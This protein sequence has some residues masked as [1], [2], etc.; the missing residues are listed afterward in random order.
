MARGL[1][2]VSNCFRK[3]RRNVQAMWLWRSVVAENALS[4]RVARNLLG[5][6]TFFKMPRSLISSAVQFPARTAASQKGKRELNLGLS[7]GTTAKATNFPRCSRTARVAKRRTSVPPGMVCRSTGKNKWTL[8]A[9]FLRRSFGKC[10]KRPKSAVRTTRSATLPC[11]KW[12]WPHRA[13]K[14]K[15]RLCCALTTPLLPHKAAADGMMLGQHC[16]T[17]TTTLRKIC[18]ALKRP[19]CKSGLHLHDY[20]VHAGNQSQFRVENPNQRGS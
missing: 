18:A 3:L 7:I 6:F 8:P 5:K 16:V 20:G 11:R 12:F 17:A 19:R 1:P 4:R 14:V 9:H 15:P 2:C 10:W 13:R